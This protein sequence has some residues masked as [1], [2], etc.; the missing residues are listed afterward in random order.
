MSST[1]PSPSER[2]ARQVFD[3]I[4]MPLAQARRSSGAPA[5]FPRTRNQDPDTYFSRPAVTRMEPPDFA[6]AG[7]GTAEGLIRETIAY[8]HQ[9]G[10]ADLCVL[11]DMMAKTASALREEAAESDG[12]VNIFCYA[13]F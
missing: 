5:Y 13:M 7:Q 11:A 12:T 3:R 10:D 2:L 9:S 6:F 1:E 8:W 4:I